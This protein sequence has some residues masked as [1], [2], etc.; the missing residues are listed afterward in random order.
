MDPISVLSVGYGRNLFRPDDIEHRRMFSCAKAVKEYHMI[1]FTNRSDKL[2]QTQFENLHL[3]PTNSQSKIHMIFDALK[4]ATQIVKEK[5]ANWVVTGQD[6]FEAGYVAYKVAKK[7]SLPLN[8]QE[9]GDFFSTKYWRQDQFLNRFRY[10]FGRRLLRQADSV[11]VVSERIKRTLVGFGI[12]EDK[13]LLLPVRSDSIDVTKGS[14]LIK[15]RKHFP[16]NELI[17]LSAG[18]FVPQKNFPLLIKA[19]SSLVQEI[20]EARLILVGAGAEEK[21]LKKLVKKNTLSKK[22]LFLPWDSSLVTLMAEA[23]IFALSSN[24]EGWARVLVE[25]MAAGTPIVTTDVGCVG[26]VLLDEEH[27]LVAP[28]NDL[29]A[30]TEKLKRLAQDVQLRTRLATN[31]KERSRHTNQNLE[32]YAI[33]WSRIFEH[34]KTLRLH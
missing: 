17:I 1:I 31:A 4:I 29:L 6:P 23:D 27:A 14:A 5:K 19:F 11:R 20:P 32:A 13:I 9:H 3:Y 16:N 2:Y 24:W 22:V 18:R 33:E 8:L 15:L 10:W 7:F 25:A 30:F 21:R 28:V 26:E 12:K 34:T